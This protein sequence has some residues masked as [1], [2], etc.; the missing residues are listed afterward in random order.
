MPLIETQ[1]LILKP[2]T[3]DDAADMSALHQDPVVMDTMQNSRTLD[4]AAAAATFAHYLAGWETHGTSLFAARLRADGQY[5]GECG[6][7]HRPDKPGLSMRY[8]LRQAFW[9]QGY[10]R[11]MSDAVTDW[12]FTET[13]EASFWAVT[14]AR[15]KASVAILR[16]LGGVV[17]ETAHTNVEGLWR[18]DVTRSGWAEAGQRLQ[19][20]EMEQ[21][22]A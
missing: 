21:N 14:Q 18:F 2:Y 7:W 1:R 3:V 22:D 9:G 15:N 12:L 8:L 11:E 20:S 6:F 4:T 13:V 16:R 19:D 10:G 17:V 5:I